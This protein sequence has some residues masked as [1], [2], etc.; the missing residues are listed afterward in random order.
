[1]FECIGEGNRPNERF[2]YYNKLS[3]DFWHEAAM[4]YIP[5]KKEIIQEAN[6]IMKKLFKA[7]NNILGVKFRGTDYIKKKPPYHQR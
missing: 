3:M 2:I 7:S 4:K 1:M 6:I 5:I